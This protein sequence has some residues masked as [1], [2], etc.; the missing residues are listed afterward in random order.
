[1]EAG[2][3]PGAMERLTELAQSSTVTAQAAVTALR[4][5]EENI[6]SRSSTT[7]GLESATKV[8][9]KPP[10]FSGDDSYT[11]WHHV[12]TSWLS[13]AEPQFAELLKVAERSEGRP[14]S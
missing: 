1:M 2:N 4:H 14:Y 8:L 3:G 6:K 11:S 13:Y 7:G 9:A 12:F 5:I 10:V